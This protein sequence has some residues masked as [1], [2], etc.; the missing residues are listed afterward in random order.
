MVS[1]TMWQGLAFSLCEIQVVGVAGP[2]DMAHLSYK[3]G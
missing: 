1:D 2:D 3:E